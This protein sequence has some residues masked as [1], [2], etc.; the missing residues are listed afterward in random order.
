MI[1][2]GVWVRVFDSIPMSRYNFW[3][4]DLVIA[5]NTLSFKYNASLVSILAN[6]P[7]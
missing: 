4:I 6:G 2:V 3:T 5:E 7:S 1:W